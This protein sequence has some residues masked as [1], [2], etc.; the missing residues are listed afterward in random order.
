MKRHI[1]TLVIMIA[2]VLLASCKSVANSG[3][4]SVHE[5]LV[6]PDVHDLAQLVRVGDALR[7]YAS[8]VEWWAYSLG[9]RD[10]YFLGDDLYDGN[11][12]DWDLGD[13]AYWAPSI[14]QSGA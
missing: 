1:H 14:V 11:N 8:A 9:D 2:A 10:S 12:P 5:P 13:A 6:L 4:A 7:L 3:D